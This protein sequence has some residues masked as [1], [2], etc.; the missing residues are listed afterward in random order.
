MNLRLDAFAGPRR[1]LIDL[2]F[3]PG[4][5]VKLPAILLLVSG[6]FALLFLAHTQKAY[7]FLV[8]IGLE[9]PWLRA[10]AREIQHDYFVVSIA[11][12]S[13]YA[14]VVAGIC[15][16]A[17]HRIF[18]PIVA[19][20]RQLDALKRGDYTSRIRL[21]AGH[22]LCGLAA[23]LNDL[24]EILARESGGKSLER[25]GSRVADATPVVSHASKAVE[26][27]LR[28]Y[29]SEERDEEPAEPDFAALAR[30]T[31]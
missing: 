15:L 7:G 18:G 1:R 27:L 12:A 19:L 3:R 23:D 13:A 31:G 17:T 4:T 20:E 28:L 29:S 14:I 2:R 9:D 21:R 10:F 8:E 6:G 16:A 11:L 30:Q 25:G 22:P 26:R 5:Q 24:C